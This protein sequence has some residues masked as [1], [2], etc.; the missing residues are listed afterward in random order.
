MAL[1]SYRCNDCCTI[2]DKEH[3]MNNK[4]KQKCSRCGSYNTYRRI[5]ISNFILRCGGFYSTDKI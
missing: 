3:S 5:T 1:Y 4:Q 2:F